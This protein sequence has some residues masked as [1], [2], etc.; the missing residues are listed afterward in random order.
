MGDG[1]NDALRGY[2]KAGMPKGGKPGKPCPHCGTW[3]YTSNQCH[4]EQGLFCTRAARSS[5][6]KP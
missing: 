5:E 2:I 3:S 6:A 1:A 4:P